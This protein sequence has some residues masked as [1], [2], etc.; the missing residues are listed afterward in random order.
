MLDYP[1]HP[2]MVS[3]T[4]V[5]AAYASGDPP[6]PKQLEDLNYIC[7]NHIPL[8]QT[9]KLLRAKDTPKQAEGVTG[10]QQFA[11]Q[12]LAMA[13]SVMQRKLGNGDVAFQNGCNAFQPKQKRQKALGDAESLLPCKHLACIG[14][15]WHLVVPLFHVF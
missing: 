3:D 10:M 8:R 5:A 4:F 9:S 11:E 14:F 2:H 12:L 1:E 15:C 6:V 7:L 13:S